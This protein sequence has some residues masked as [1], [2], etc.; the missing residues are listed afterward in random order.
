M[1]DLQRVFPHD[2]P[3]NE[4]LQDPLPLGQRRLIEP[5]PHPLAERRQVGPDLF[6][7]L[8]LAAQSLLLVPLGREHQPPPPD[9]FTA[10]LEFVEVDRFGLVGVEEPLL[11][12]VEPTQQGLALLARRVRVGIARVGLP[13][14][15]LELRGQRRRVVEQPFDM[16][17]DGRVELLD[18]GPGLRAR[19]RPVP[20]QG[21]LAVT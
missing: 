10:L 20:C 4:Q 17:P 8:T 7:G 11:L 16:A 3:L 21:V 15:L 12:A 13:G 6:R 19:A 2:D 18:P 5:R 14:P 1:A 9:L